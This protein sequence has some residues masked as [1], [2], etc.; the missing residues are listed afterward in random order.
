MLNSEGTVVS[1]TE[2]CLPPWGLWV[3]NL[4]SQMQRKRQGV[5]QGMTGEVTPGDDA[6][7]QAR[8]VNPKRRGWDD[9]AGEDRRQM[10]RVSPKDLKGNQVTGTER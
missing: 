1:K 10:T 7:A 4:S 3:W 9:R 8:Y 2:E 6:E 5:M